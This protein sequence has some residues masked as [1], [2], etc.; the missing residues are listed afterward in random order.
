M[1]SA[2]VEKGVP[3]NR[4]YLGRAELAYASAALASAH[5]QGAG[6]FTARCHTWLEDTTGCAKALLTSSCTAALEMAALL[7]GIKPGDEVV[8]PSYTFVSTA[9][10]FVLRGAIPVFVDIDPRTQNLDP[11]RVAAA[12]TKRTKAIVPVH[13]AGVGCDMDAIMAI[14]EQHGLYV[15]E[16]AAQGLMATYKGRALGSIGHLGTI[17]FHDTKNTSCGEGG[18]LLIRDKALIERALVLWEKGTDRQKMLRGEVDKYTWVD[19]GSSFLPSDI[20][21]A[22][23]L[24]QLEEAAATAEDRRRTWMLYHDA[25]EEAEREGIVVRPS[26]PAECRH[27]GHLYYLLL[28]SAAARD[29][30]IARLRQRGIGTPFHYVPLHSSPAGRRFGRVH[31]PMRATLRA[32][33]CL[34][35][36]PLWRGMTAEDVET[37]IREGLAVLAE[38]GGRV[39]PH[40]PPAARRGTPA[41][42]LTA[43][44]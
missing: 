2:D 43:G 40:I 16:D 14:A 37:V 31:G 30:F 38:L 35:R 25:F 41:A 3:F 15:V 11:A 42:A 9:N 26:V 19:V 22:I 12:I 29:A 20:T 8:M 21:A 36:L 10:A 27:N 44:S 23:L 34:V 39:A 1:K 28:P 32:G 4:P 18:A 7:L 6:P 33:A 13:Y 17:S 5:R 24:G